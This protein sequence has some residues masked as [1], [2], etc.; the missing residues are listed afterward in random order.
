MIRPAVAADAAAVSALQFRA[1][2]RA[3]EDILDP[4]AFAAYDVEGRLARWELVLGGADHGTLVAEVAG[5]VRG[6]VSVGSAEPGV[7]E[8]RELYVDPP[9][10]GAGVGTELLSSGEASMLAQGLD[11]ALLWVLAD[12]GLARGF[13]EGR[14]WSAVAG[15]GRAGEHGADEIQYEKSL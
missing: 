5:A 10:W 1:W 4:M 6:F 8:V 9:A 7:G 3:F 13:Y 15:S 12:N 11:R 2:L 14:G